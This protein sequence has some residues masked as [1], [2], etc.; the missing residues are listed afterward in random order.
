MCNVTYDNVNQLIEITQVMSFK[1]N[2]FVLSQVWQ[3]TLNQIHNTLHDT[4]CTT[5][6]GSIQIYLLAHPASNYR[7]RLKNCFFFNLLGIAGGPRLWGSHRLHPTRWR[8]RFYS[9]WSRWRPWCEPRHTSTCT[10]CWGPRAHPRYA[11][12]G[13]LS[14]WQTPAT[15]TRFKTQCGRLSSW[16]TPATTTRFNPAGDQGRK[17]AQM[18][19]PLM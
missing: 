12:C 6:I 4:L 8:V 9:S 5:L 2:M 11:R 1:V 3:L 13:R 14:S 10:P 16:Q 19:L 18:H 15:T 17:S 7:S